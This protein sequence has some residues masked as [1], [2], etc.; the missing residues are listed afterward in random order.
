MLKLKKDIFIGVGILPFDRC[1]CPKGQTS[2]RSAGQ[3]SR[4][5]EKMPEEYV[6]YSVVHPTVHYC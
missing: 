5:Y 3:D 1:V 6:L 2:P 4:G